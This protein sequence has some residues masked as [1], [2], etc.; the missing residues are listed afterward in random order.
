MEKMLAYIF[1]RQRYSEAAIRHFYRAKQEQAS[2]NG[3][4]WL[5]AMANAATLW[6][7]KRRLAVLEKELSELKQ[8][9][10]E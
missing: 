9:K 3:I 8:Q 10:G 7:Y 4:I 2:F 5:F 6:C 1:E